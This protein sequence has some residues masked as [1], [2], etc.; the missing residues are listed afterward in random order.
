MQLVPQPGA[1]APL[2]WWRPTRTAPDVPAPV[3]QSSPVPFAAL[4][5]FTIILLLAPQARFPILAPL[6]LAALGAGIAIGALLWDRSTHHRR[7][8]RW[9]RE[10]WLVAGLLAWSLLT[11]PFSY[12]PGG[13]LA[14][15]S[16]VYLKSIAIL[17]L[18]AAVVDT[19]DRLRKLAWTLTAISVPLAGTAVWN[20]VSS[21]FISEEGEAVRRI[22]GYDAPL[23]SNPNDLA[24]MINLMVPLAFALFLIHRRPLVR[25]ALAAIIVLDAV[26][27]V[28]TF[29]RAGFLT[30]ATVLAACF[31]KLSRRPERAWA[32]GALVAALLC[33]A[34]LP[35]GYLGRLGTITSVA[36]DPTGSSQTR[37]ADT[38]TAARFVAENP[39][40]GAGLGMNVLAL[41]QV[42]GPTWTEVH[43]VYLEYAADLGLPGLLAFLAL[44][45]SCTAGVGLVRRRAIREGRGEQ[46]L[47]LAESLRLS[48][49]AFALAGIFH[50][51]AYQFYF[52][53][54][55]GLAI[56]L[57]N[58]S[59]GTASVAPAPERRLPIPPPSLAVGKAG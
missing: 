15:L 5:F 52:Y 33:I 9:S 21:A 43:N 30:L 38:L 13:S 23:T 6:H 14:L 48:L 18:L 8:V 25:A 41:N 29:S 22:A 58:I 42:R 50:P 56:A 16:G 3:S 20:F 1:A 39:I 27:V 59:G 51:I 47:H 24:L 36:S 2:E 7:S 44:L 26:A 46:L 32:Y 12:W 17:W 4:V 53:Y 19:T 55:A 54:F 57:R 28:V 37:W 45:W 31:W 35:G 49:I 10:H 40:F 11:A 34:L